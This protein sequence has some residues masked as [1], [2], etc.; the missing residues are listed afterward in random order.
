[1]SYD[2]MEPRRSRSC[3]T[4]FFFSKLKFGFKLAHVSFQLKSSPECKCFRYTKT[5]WNITPLPIVTK[6]VIVYSLEPFKVQKAHKFM[7]KLA[8]SEMAKHG[9]S[10]GSTNT[11]R[12][13]GLIPS[14]L[15]GAGWRGVCF[16]ICCSLSMVKFFCYN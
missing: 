7:A 1:M 5:I 4:E 3:R 9:N 2:D 16:Y 6:L 10:S 8:L 11:P 14:W 15:L 12:Q 13:R